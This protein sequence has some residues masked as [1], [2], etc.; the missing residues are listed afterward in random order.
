MQWSLTIVDWYIFF[1]FNLIRFITLELSNMLNYYCLDLADGE[2]NGIAA[3]DR[4]DLMVVAKK[5]VYSTY[6]NDLEYNWDLYWL[7][8]LCC[9]YPQFERSA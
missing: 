1:H 6:Q 9:Q 8:D 4:Q 3:T 2:K 5:L 7:S